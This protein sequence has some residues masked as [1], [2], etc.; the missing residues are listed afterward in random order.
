MIYAGQVLVI[1]VA[2]LTTGQETIQGGIYTVQPGDSL[3]RIAEKAY[4]NGRRW[5]RIYEANTDKISDASK[6]YVGQTLVI[7]E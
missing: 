4:G 3:W 6:I 1:N 5:R 2:W 7:P